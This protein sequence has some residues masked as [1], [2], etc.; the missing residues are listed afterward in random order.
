MFLYMY[1]DVPLYILK[2]Y[3]LVNR[4]FYYYNIY[5]LIS[6]NESCLKLYFLYFTCKA[7]NKQKTSLQI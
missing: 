1:S 3:F 7:N 5:L 4:L 2:L 6:S